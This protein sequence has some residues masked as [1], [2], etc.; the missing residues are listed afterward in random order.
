MYEG[1]INYK[2]IVQ[3]INF[4]KIQLSFKSDQIMENRLSE[5][6][7]KNDVILQLIDVLDESESSFLKLRFI[8][9]LTH[10][11]IS[12]VLGC[13]LRQSLRIQKRVLTKVKELDAISESG[14]I[15]DVQVVNGLH[16]IATGH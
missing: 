16:A 2:K 4:L 8:D 13:S 15:T 3:Q 7:H 6:E 5:L 11:Q 14:G 1:V 12:D 10:D 9:G